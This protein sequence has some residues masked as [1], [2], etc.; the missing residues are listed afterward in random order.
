MSTSGKY[1]CETCHFA[2]NNKKDFNRHLITSRHVENMKRES[3]S[4]SKNSATNFH[5]ECGKYYKTKRGFKI[6]KISC[7]TV[8]ISKPEITTPEPEITI[9]HTESKDILASFNADKMT[10]DQFLKMK[11]LEIRE[12][13][14]DNFG[15][16]MEIEEKKFGIDKKSVNNTYNSTNNNSVHSSY[17]NNSNNV[18]NTFNLQLFL[19]D[20]CKDAMNLM[21]FVEMIKCTAADAEC[22]SRIGYAETISKLMIDRLQ[23]MDITKRPIHCTDTKREK[24]YIKDD[25]EWSKD[26]VS[27]GKL[28][29]AIKAIGHKSMKGIEEWKEKNPPNSKGSSSKNGKYLDMCNKTYAGILDEDNKEMKKIIKKIAPETKINK[30]DVQDEIAIEQSMTKEDIS[31]NGD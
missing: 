10:F 9:P 23:D 8:E 18:N 15:R 21:D 14:V 1:K 27:E 24:M 31:V 11:E 17:N 28:R 5:C 29:K 2:T 12:K 7:N 16:K 30:E 20:T 4:L 22:V 6:H 3:L 25:D 19:N 26:S 13:E